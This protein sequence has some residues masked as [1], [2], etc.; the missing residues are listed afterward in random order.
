[1]KVVPATLLVN[2]IEVVAPEQIVCD[3]GVAVATGVGLTVIVTIMGAPGHP[4]AVGVTV[5]VAVP[6]VTPVAV[7]VCAMLDPLDA[8]APVTPDC[9]TVQLKVVP[10]TLLLNAME[11][12]APEQIVCEDGVAVTTGV[13]LTVMTTM[14]GVPGHPFADGVMVY[15][16]VPGV[17]PV[18][19]NTWAI[20]EPLDAEAPDTPDCATVQL[21]VVP[22]TLLVN[23]ID[24]VPP[25]QMVC[26][27]GVA[28][29]TGVGL[30]VMMTMTG[31][32]GHPFAV[33]LI[34]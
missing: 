1:M 8:E 24:V 22:A 11:V 9:T 20:L 28:T 23:A 34:V 18:A 12:V 31:V 13:G 26:E 14:I 17:A 27:D 15:V 3:D 4:F 7:K 2:A 33:E 5:Y 16:A 6:G 21:K 10:A 29:A 25:E 30:T 32:P 19:D